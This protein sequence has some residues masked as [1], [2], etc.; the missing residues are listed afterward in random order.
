MEKKELKIE[1]INL[2]KPFATGYE[3]NIVLYTSEQGKEDLLKFYKDKTTKNKSFSYLYS[4]ETTPS[5]EEVRK[6][7]EEK[8]IKLS[9]IDDECLVKIK[10]AIY[11]KGMLV[12]YTMDKIK[13]K[14][15]N[16]D[17][18]TRKD[19]IEYLLKIRENMER[20][21]SKGVYI[22]DFNTRNFIIKEDGNIMHLD[23]DNYRIGNNDFDTKTKYVYE[24]DRYGGDKKLIDNYC[25]DIF[26]IS[27]LGGYALGYFSVSDVRLPLF[28]RSKHNKEVLED[29]YSLGINYQGKILEFKKK[30]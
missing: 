26:A 30:N 6:N 19:K 21:N 9:N 4:D 16:V 2:S 7:K 5:L 3:S 28:L 22:G 29:M 8:I 13:G 12:G 1:N 10:D 15:F 18:A 14:S 23:I 20:L 24:Y 11:D 17:R 27:I 25:Y